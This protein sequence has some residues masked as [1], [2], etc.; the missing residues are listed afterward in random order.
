MTI[1]NYN[2]LQLATYLSSG[3]LSNL[4]VTYNNIQG[5]YTFTNT[6]NNFRFTDSGSTAYNLLGLSTSTTGYTQSVSKSLKS[7][8][9]VNLCS[10]HCIHI[11]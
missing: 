7:P 5:T 11:C 4:K 9:V 3:V 8:N 6:T 10:K 1:G 2:V